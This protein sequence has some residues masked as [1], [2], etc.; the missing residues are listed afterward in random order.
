LSA[1]LLKDSRQAGITNYKG[2]DLRN[3][4]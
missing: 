3:N 4:N 2:R 1:I